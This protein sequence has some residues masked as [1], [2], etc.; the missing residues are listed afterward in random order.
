MAGVVTAGVLYLVIGRAAAGNKG[1][2]GASGASSTAAPALAGAV[3]GRSRTPLS[4]TPASSTPTPA[5][6]LSAPATGSSAINPPRPPTRTT[7]I[8][9]FSENTD[10]AHDTLFKSLGFNAAIASASRSGL[11]NAAANG[12]KAFVWLGDYDD[13]SCTLEKSDAQ[14]TSAVAAVRS[15]PALLGYF[16][17]DEPEQAETHCPRV[18]AQIK[19]RSA[20]IRSLDPNRAHATFEVISNQGTNLKCYDYAT[21]M[22]ATDIMALDIYPFRQDASYVPCVSD[23]SKP[24]RD[25]AQAIAA[26]KR[27]AA[28][29]RT[30]H[31]GFVP[32]FYGMAQ[33]FEDTIWRRP[34]VADLRQQYAA[35]QN[36]GMEGWWYFSWDWQAH[37]LDGN[38]AHACEF[39][40]E[41]GLSA[42]C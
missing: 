29:Y 31:P 6:S 22:G 23:A 37:S 25:I 30:A 13:S 1:V 26:F 39:K 35:W 15:H 27:Q 36:S 38:S 10:G 33:D 11:D 19:A 40:R 9:G 18:V 41:N 8:R 3:G 21:F 16:V 42:N 5:P 32:R 28:A 24:L 20:F 2:E 7:L 4:T 17:A 14:I 12:M 34:T